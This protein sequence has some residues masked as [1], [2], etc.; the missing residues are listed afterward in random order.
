[1][2]GLSSIP[3]FDSFYFC[4]SYSRLAKL[5]TVSSYTGFMGAEPLARCFAMTRIILC[6]GTD[7]IK[8]GTQVRRSPGFSSNGGRGALYRMLRKDSY[9]PCRGIPCRGTYPRPNG[10]EVYRPFWLL[11]GAWFRIEQSHAPLLNQQCEYM[12]A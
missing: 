3:F 1:L 11:K 5:P 10:C 7:V 9:H 12:I 6:K 4:F 8:K 2:R